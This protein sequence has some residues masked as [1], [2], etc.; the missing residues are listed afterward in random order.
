M[1]EWVLNLI[2]NLLKTDGDNI[3]YIYG[4]ID[5][6]SA[7]MFEPTEAETRDNL[8]LMIAVLQELSDLA[9]QDADKLRH[10]PEMT[11]SRRLDEYSLAKNPVLSLRKD[12]DE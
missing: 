2:F 8:D 10:M 6:W 9:Y 11:A 3:V 4:E 12:K 7:A 5:P 1:K